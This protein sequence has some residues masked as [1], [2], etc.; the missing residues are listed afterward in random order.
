MP[1]KQRPITCVLVMAMAGI[2]LGPG[3]ARAQLSDTT[4]FLNIVEFWLD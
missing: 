1:K 3:A 4:A 2:L